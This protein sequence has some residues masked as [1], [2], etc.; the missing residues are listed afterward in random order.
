MQKFQ[1]DLPVGMHRSPLTY[2]PYVL[3]PLS[4]WSCL[5]SPIPFRNLGNSPFCP[6]LMS[7]LGR[8]R[9]L[10]SSLDSFLTADALT[11]LD[12]TLVLNRCSWNGFYLFLFNFYLL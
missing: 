8:D 10:Q 4:S 5:P 2:L 7:L 11:W 9:R 1:Q 3:A 6:K 12:F